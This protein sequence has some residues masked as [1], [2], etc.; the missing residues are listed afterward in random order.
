[1]GKTG[2]WLKKRADIAGDQF[3]KNVVRAAG[4]ATALVLTGAFVRL[5]SDAHNQIDNLIRMVG[6]WLGV[7]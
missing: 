4:T 7:G 2:F 1:M 5:V 3:A 6:E